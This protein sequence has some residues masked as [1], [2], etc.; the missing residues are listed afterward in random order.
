MPNP[1]SQGTSGG[2]PPV[3]HTPRLAMLPATPAILNALLAR[4]LASAEDLTGAR[5]PP[6]WAEQAAAYLTMR[7][8]ELQADPARQLWLDRLVVLRVD[9]RPLAGHVGFHGPPDNGGVLEVGYRVLEAY[10]KRGIASEAV[11]GLLDWASG[12]AGVTTFRASIAPHNA[13]SLRLAGRLG[14]HQVGRQVDENDGEELVLEVNWK[15]GTTVT[16]E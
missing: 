3:I 15:V 16:P 9:E 5:I 12:A 13:P 8:G 14:F 4:D 11:K 10:R 1:S 7:L 2:L 6:A